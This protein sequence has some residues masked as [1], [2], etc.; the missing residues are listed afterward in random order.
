MSYCQFENTYRDLLQCL[1]AMNDDLS[2]SERG[3]RGRLVEVCQEIIEEYELVKMSEEEDEWD[4]DIV[5]LE[6]DDEW[7]DDIPNTNYGVDGL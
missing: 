6:R 7:N 1:N 4:D 5:E 2:E 3:Y